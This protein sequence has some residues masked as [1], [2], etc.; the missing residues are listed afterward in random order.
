MIKT[1]CFIVN[2]NLYNSKRYFVNRLVEALK[3]EGI[4][5]FIFDTKGGALEAEEIIEL[6]RRSPDFTCSFNN[7][8]P[9]KSGKYLWDQMEIPHHTYLV[10]PPV[11]WIHLTRSPYSILSCNDI[12][13]LHVL[14]SIHFDRR[15]FLPHAVERERV[16]APL[17]F[18]ERPYDVVMIGS[19]Y[20]HETIKEAWR[21]TFSKEVCKVIDEAIDLCFSSPE[22]TFS[23]AVHQTWARSKLD[24]R[25]VDFEKICECVDMYTRGKDRVELIRSIKDVEVH[26]FGRRY[27]EESN[28]MRHWKDY[29]GDCPNVVIHDLLEY[30]Q[31]FDVLGQSKICL[32]SNP[33][34]RNGSHE[35]YFN[36]L[37]MGCAIIG[38]VNSYMKKE[39]G[40]KRGV[41]EYQFNA[42]DKVNDLVK[43]ILADEKQRLERVEEG[44]KK[45]AEG[46]TWDHRAQTMIEIIPQMIEK[47]TNYPKNGS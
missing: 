29:V 34:I 13:D 3:R 4:Q 7:I 11:F 20:D 44:R 15:F 35:R 12:D 17:D 14:E 41:Y 45:I 27:W 38:N 23:H 30:E 39:F 47:I 28:K 36:G 6:Q 19:C 8:F 31:I 2:D 9:L 21:K 43:D 24:P 33:A 1:I 25:G 18:R 46:H 5:S 37:A 40:E 10:D 32:H 42:R 26:I 16:A 22:T